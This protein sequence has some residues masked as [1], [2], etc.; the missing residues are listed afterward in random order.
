[1][2][3]LIIFAIV[4]LSL[5][6]CGKFFPEESMSQ[7]EILAENAKAFGFHLDDNGIMIPENFMPAT[8]TAFYKILPGTFWINVYTLEIDGL[9]NIATKDHFDG[10]TSGIGRTHLSIERD[11]TFV[12]YFYDFDT[13]EACY[14][15]SDV[16]FVNGYGAFR[17]AGSSLP[18]EHLLLTISESFM[19]T[20]D[21]IG[22]R[23]DD[24][25]FCYTVFEKCTDYNVDNIK[26][27]Y[28]VQR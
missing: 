23:G 27:Q 9:G 5:I 20:I 17:T 15:I 6:S 16:D 22:K 21:C 18:Y 3:R 13:E 8:D 10:Q 4:S 19:E 25:I 24:Y 11:S 12:K 28:N 2:K 14:S 7:E 26:R 1:M